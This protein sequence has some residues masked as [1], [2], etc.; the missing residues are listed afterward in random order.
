MGYTNEWV[1]F[2]LHLRC[3]FRLLH[4]T[5]YSTEKLLVL[6]RDGRK[7]L[8]TLR[9]FDQF[10]MVVSLDSMLSFLAA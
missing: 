4:Y 7:L 6:L 9:S 5:T 2:F 8:G 3:L 10:G 1:V